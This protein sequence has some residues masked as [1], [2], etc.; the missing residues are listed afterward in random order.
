MALNTLCACK[1]LFL[2]WTK[3]LSSTLTRPK[4]Y[5]EIRKS[6]KKWSIL[7]SYAGQNP[8][9]FICNKAIAVLHYEKALHPVLLKLQW[10]I[11]D[12]FRYSLNKSA[13]SLW[14]QRVA[15]MHQT[16]YRSWTERERLLA[17][18][19]DVSTDHKVKEKF[20]N[21]KIRLFNS[22]T[23]WKSKALATDVF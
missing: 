19:V 20:I 13:V 17:V 16:L 2:S 23:I 14:V 10:N 3:T 18:F 11:S 6:N 1:N 22:T 8:K 12:G 9:C 7:F 15:I 21:L 5:K 4:V